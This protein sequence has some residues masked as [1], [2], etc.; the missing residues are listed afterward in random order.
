MEK[1]TSPAKVIP[2]SSKLGGQCFVLTGTWPGLGGEGLTAGKEVV[3][4]GIEKH[5]GK[6][7]SGFSNVTNFLVI[8]TLPGPKKVL[9]AYDKGI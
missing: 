3:K 2:L 1:P 6:V 8:G 5:G 9:D 4:V 7:T